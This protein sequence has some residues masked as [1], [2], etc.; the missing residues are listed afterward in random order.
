VL[1]N[2]MTLDSLVAE[3]LV[4]QFGE[5]SGGERKAKA[6]PVIPPNIFLYLSHQLGPP[7]A[8]DVI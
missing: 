7:M 4:W 5:E 1:G 8:R 6:W 3:D 2:R